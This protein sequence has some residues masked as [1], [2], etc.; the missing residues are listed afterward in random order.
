[1]GNFLKH[2]QQPPSIVGDVMVGTGKGNIGLF[3]F[4]KNNKTTNGFF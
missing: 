4:L 1:M 3:T 2:L